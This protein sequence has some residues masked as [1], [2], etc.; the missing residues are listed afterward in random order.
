MK[1]LLRIVPALAGVL[2]SIPFAHA[3]SYPSKP[4]RV[5]VPFSPGGGTDIL[6]RLLAPKLTERLGQPVI[7]DNRAGAAG[8]LGT[9]FT[10]RSAPDGHTLQVGSTSEIGIGATLHTKVP[11]KLMHDLAVV[12]ALASTPMTLVV[13]PSLPVKTVKDLIALAKSRPG[14]LNYGSAGAGTGN[15][16]CGELFRYL[17]KAEITHIPYKGAAP[18]LADVVGG[19]VHIMFSTVPAAVGLIQAGR[20]RAL[21]VSTAQRYRALPGVPTMIEA[22]VANYDVEY[23]YGFFAPAATPVAIIE[24]IENETSQQLRNPEMISS[25]QARGLDPIHKTRKE[26]EAF[27]KMDIERWAPAV[28]ASGAKGF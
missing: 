26:F 28:K 7:V 9:D 4:I 6:A 10:V 13:H 18:A 17:T 11:Y 20:L 24:R 22:G 8:T 23:W 16:M 14:E 21:A 19:Q 27:V 25:L 1:Q 3:Q 5:V 15:H 12:A 2:A